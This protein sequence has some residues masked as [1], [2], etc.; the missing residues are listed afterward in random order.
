MFGLV[1][2]LLDLGHRN[3]RI[4]RCNRLTRLAGGQRG[5]KSSR[6]CECFESRLMALSRGWALGS[7]NGLRL[8]RLDG[9]MWHWLGRRL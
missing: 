8:R 7:F 5:G 1:I 9:G 2:I 3:S 4:V 6:R